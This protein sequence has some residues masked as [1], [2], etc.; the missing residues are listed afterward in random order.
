[1]T[2]YLEKRI[3][4]HTSSF[5]TKNGSPVTTALRN[6]FTRLSTDNTNFEVHPGVLA[7]DPEWI[8]LLETVTERASEEFP[9]AEVHPNGYTTEDGIS[10]DVLT[11]LATVSGYVSYPPAIPHPSSPT[12]RDLELPIARDAEIEEFGHSAKVDYA[13]WKGSLEENIL[14]ENLSFFTTPTEITPFAV[15]SKTSMGALLNFVSPVIKQSIMDFHSDPVSSRTF[16]DMLAKRDFEGLARLNFYFANINGTRL[17]PDGLKL[18]PAGLVSWAKRRYSMKQRQTYSTHSDSL[19]LADK[20][21]E[22]N[23]RILPACRE[24]QTNVVPFAATVPAGVAAHGLA[25][26][27]KQFAI[28][29]SGEPD[30]MRGVLRL[31]ELNADV[32]LFD[33]KM[34]DSTNPV[35]PLGD[36]NKMLLDTCGIVGLLLVL[37]SHVPLMVFGTHKNKV[38]MY[39]NPFDPSTWIVRYTIASGDWATT[40]KTILCNEAHFEAALIRAGDLDR[41]D[42]QLFRRGIHP[43]LA[44]VVIGDNLVAVSSKPLNVNPSHFRMVVAEPAETLLGQEFRKTDSGFKL[45]ASLSNYT[46]K[47]WKEAP[48]YTPRNRYPY[49]GLLARR[50]HYSSHP[51][52]ADYFEFEDELFERTFGKTLIDDLHDNKARSNGPDFEGMPAPVRD[53]FV[54]DDIIHYKDVNQEVFEQYKE[55]SN[56][57]VVF[58]PAFIARTFSMFAQPAPE[59]AY[60]FTSLRSEIY[61]IK[62][63]T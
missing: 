1:M 55:L 60:Q 13:S 21:K 5:F 34:S 33:I 56:S 23:G 61:P 37:P 58:P 14:K 15:K 6:R 19:V 24:R 43:T 32:K 16:Y 35:E 40:L 27:L 45:Q 41:K 29:S 46:W 20:A 53:L 3:L 47:L 4:D 54:N 10:K 8:N 18:D 2:K 28:A 26:Q 49:E 62:E 22:I 48:L 59:W 63:I 42:V 25:A 50:E 31:D 36:I 39:G 12:L 9:K 51:L 38:V 52:S 7:T 11:K 44:G 30:V 17:Q 57:Y